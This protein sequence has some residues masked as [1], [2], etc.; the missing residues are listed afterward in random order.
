MWRGLFILALLAQ[1]SGVA[2]AEPPFRLHEAANAPDW[3][4]LKGEARVRYESLEGQFRAGREGSDQLLLFRSLFLAEADAGPVAFGMELQD[5]RTYLGDAGTPL[6]SSIANPLDFLQL[7]AR[8]E[9]LPGL[10]G[11]GSASRLTLGRQT[12]SIGSKRQIERVDFANVIKSYTGAHF[13]STAARGD[14]LHAIYVV[15]TAR[16]PNTR[17]ALDDNELSGDEEQWERRIWGLHYRRADILPGLAPDLWGEIYVYGLEERDSGDFQ[18]PDRSYTAPGFRLYRK[19]ETGQWDLDLEVALRQGTRYATSAPADTQSLEVNAQMAFLALGYTFDLPWQ[20]RIAYEHYYAS[21]DEDPGD[22]NFDQH[23]RLFGSRR[24]DLNNTSIHG[25]LTPANLNAPGFRVEVKPNA[26]WDGRFYYHA[27]FL[28]SETDSW[29][30]ARRRDPTGQSGD[31]IGH[32]LD[33]RARY[34]L[35]P[36]S[37]RLEIGASALIY[38]DFAKNV[39]G[40]PEGDGTAFGYLQLTFSF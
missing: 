30:I 6:S 22:L 4:T 19:P 23:E 26:R 16:F 36:D 20:P 14:E 10:L 13:V 25:P 8:A 12:V 32:T 24:S 29:V 21:G 27:A 18:T 31:F 5:S 9:A 15:P 34:W 40:G 2:G 37:L 28:A 38:G 33:G 3:L 17:P 11:E 7:Y 39:P 1:A 35:V